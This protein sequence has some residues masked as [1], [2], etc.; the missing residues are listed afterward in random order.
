MPDPSSPT[1]LRASERRNDPR[2]MQHAGLLDRLGIRRRRGSPRATLLQRLPSLPAAAFY[3]AIYLV[4]PLLLPFGALLPLWA[5][6]TRV[7]EWRAARDRCARRCWFW[8]AVAHLL[9][10][11]AVLM[12]A[13]VAL[14]AV[15]GGGWSVGEWW[16]SLGARLGVQRDPQFLLLVDVATALVAA[17]LAVG[18]SRCFGYVDEEN[19][20]HPPRRR[21]SVR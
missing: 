18:V 9:F 20:W 6:V 14:D 2:R 11:Y 13:L 7:R 1:A 16:P 10:A 15:L 17:L 8:L 19:R 5:L 3:L 12:L 21:Q 4:I